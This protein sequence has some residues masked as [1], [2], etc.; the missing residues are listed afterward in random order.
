M[1]NGQATII[2][3]VMTLTK[4]Q[5]PCISICTLDEEDMCM[6]CLRT[7]DEIVDW[8]ML[9]DDEKRSVLDNVAERGRLRNQAV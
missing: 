5:S 9:S 3:R 8:T 2:V 4:P 1:N 7:L 6:G